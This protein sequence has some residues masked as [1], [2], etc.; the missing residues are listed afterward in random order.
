MISDNTSFFK[1]TDDKPESSTENADEDFKNIASEELKVVLTEDELLFFQVVK[2]KTILN[3][4][5]KSKQLKKVGVMAQLLVET[6]FKDP[7]IKL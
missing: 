5:M 7:V 4:S 1:T 6:V 3:S 2:Q